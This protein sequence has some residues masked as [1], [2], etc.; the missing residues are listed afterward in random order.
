MISISTSRLVIRDHE[1]ADLQPMHELYSSLEEM[2]FLPN[3][4]T[5]TID[6]TE[7]KLG[8]C[9]AAT[10]QS[11]RATYYFAI[12]DRAARDYIGEIGYRI[13]RRT[14][15]DCTA[16]LGYFIRRGY[17]NR[18]IATEAAQAVLVDAFDNRHVHKM[19]AGC[20]VENGASERV[21]LKLGFAKEATLRRHQFH[22]GV[23]KDRVEFALLRAER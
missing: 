11:P 22:E 14:D 17:W 19:T 6:E 13:T 18:G 1:E 2:R 7:R 23:W 5:A 16:D 20:L 3:L 21:L 15:R 4:M 10:R 9:L 12:V 8:E